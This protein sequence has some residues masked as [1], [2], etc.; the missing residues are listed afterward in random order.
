MSWGLETWDAAGQKLLYAD[1]G[2]LRVIATIHRVY[3][4]AGSEV[5][6]SYGPMA[7][8]AGWVVI[9]YPAPLSEYNAVTGR[10]E[11]DCFC[12]VVAGG[13]YVRDI[14]TGGTGNKQAHFLICKYI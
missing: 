14:T 8:D 1:D 6:V 12:R 7:E 5:F 4:S 11:A 2:L 9:Q 3:F 10:N 13:F